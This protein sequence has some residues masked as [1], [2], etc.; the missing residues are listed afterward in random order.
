MER[1]NG[2]A[3]AQVCLQTMRLWNVEQHVRGMVF[4]TTV[5]N[6]GLHRGACVRTEEALGHELIWIA[7]WHHVI[8]V[9]LAHVFA[10]IFSP[11]GNPETD[12]F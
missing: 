3:Q 5:S 2:E 1:G 11:T 8:E 6:T 12:L 10:L 9:V 4:D 7:C